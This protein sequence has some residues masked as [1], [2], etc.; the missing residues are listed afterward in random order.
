MA[1]CNFTMFVAVA[2]YCAIQPLFKWLH[3]C[4]ICIQAYTIPLIIA[5]SDAEGLILCLSYACERMRT[6]FQKIQ[7]FLAHCEQTEILVGH[8]ATEL[9][10]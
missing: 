7:A 4:Y 5:P 1:Y 6:A 2:V 8:L 9:I 3:Y 10:D